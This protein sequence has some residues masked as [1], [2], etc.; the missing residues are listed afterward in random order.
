MLTEK[1]TRHKLHYSTYKTS[2]VK[3]R[4]IQSK[5]I[6]TIR[7]SLLLT[8]DFSCAICNW[9]IK[10]LERDTINS[11]VEI[12]HI[13]GVMKNGETS[14][15][16]CIVLCPN[17]HKLADLKIISVE[18]LNKYKKELPN[19]ITALKNAHEILFR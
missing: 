6:A 14:Y 2:N 10:G 13:I 16:N 5:S 17:H 12:H 18:E 3:L 15:D 8:Y 7:N 1:E 19:H 11:G 9:N 4:A